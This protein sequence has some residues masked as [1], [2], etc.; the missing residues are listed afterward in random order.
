[1]LKVGVQVAEALAEIHAAHI[2]H[3]D[4]N[5]ANILY[6]PNTGQVKLIDFGLASRLSRE[7]PRLSSPEVMEGTLAYISPEQTGRMNCTVDF[8][9][10]LYSFGATLY[11]LLSG[12]PPFQIDEARKLVQCHLAQVP[13]TLSQV[14]PNVPA[15]LSELVMKL[16]SKAPERRYQSALGVKADLEEC[17][18]R[19]GPDGSIASFPL[20][21]L[22]FCSK[23]LVSQKLYGREQEKKRLLEGFEGIRQGKKEL[24]LVSGYS[25]VGKTALIRELHRP[26]LQRQGAFLSGKFDQLQRS[27]PYSAF[28]QAFGSFC[29]LLMGEPGERYAEW[30]STLQRALAPNGQ[31]LVEV[32]PELERILGPQPPVPELPPAERQHRFQ[33]VFEQLVGAVADPAHPLVLFIDDLQWADLASLQL[34]HQILRS[35]DIEALYL[36]GA[37]RDNEVD[38]THP[39]S[40]TLQAME[41]EG[42]P[43]QRLPLAPLGFDAVHQLV[44]DTLRSEPAATRDLAELFCLRSDGNPF[45]LNELLEA[46]CEEG[47]LE[48]D[49]KTYAWRWELSRLRVHPLTDR[50]ADL[51]A[52]KIQKLDPATREVLQVVACL[53]NHVAFADLA[54]ALDR[55]ASDL[56]TS[57]EHLQTAAMLVQLDSSLAETRQEY[58]FTHDKVQQSAYATLSKEQRERWHYGIGKKLLERSGEAAAFE[59]V[60]HWSLCLDLLREPAEQVSLSSMAL[61]AGK[62]AKES[63]AFQPALEYFKT[64]IALFDPGWW[65]EQA[66]L[67]LEL[68]LE[69][70][71]AHSLNGQYDQMERCLSTA[72]PHCRAPEERRRI[73]E[74]RILADISRNRNQEAVQGALEALAQLGIH[75]PVRATRPHIL[76]SLLKTRAMLLGRSPEVLLGLLDLPSPALRTAMRLMVDIGSAAYVSDINLYV[77]LVLRTFQISIRYGSTPYASVAYTGYGVLLCGVLNDPRIGYRYGQLALKNLDRFNE[78]R[79]RGY[80]QFVVATFITHWSRPLSETLKLYQDGYRHAIDNGDMIFASHLA[81]HYCLNACYCTAI[82]LDQVRCACAA[83]RDKLLQI[84]K[85]QAFYTLAITHQV[86][87]NLVNAPDDPGLLKGVAYDEESMLPIHSGTQDYTLVFCVYFTKL[88]LCFLSCDHLR[89]FEYAKKAREH[90][91]VVLGSYAFGVYHFYDSLVCLALDPGHAPLTRRTLLLR[92]QRNQRKLRRWARHAPENYLQKYLLV[93][94]ERLRLLGKDE[95]ATL[96]YDRAIKLAREHRF[97]SDEAHALEL[98]GL[99]HLSRDNAKLAKSYLQEARYAYLK[100]GVHTK[101]RDLDRRHAELGIGR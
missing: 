57:L 64:G 84:G 39:W 32:L 14:A 4:L 30:R 17:L 95:K 78:R 42:C 23:L 72:L 56:L 59:I 37:Y 33:H 27:R 101:V 87:L 10:D 82:E 6:N 51:M 94:A 41:Q 76:L 66:A 8:R 52:R 96:V 61:R 31:V 80:V 35:P 90:L 20:G 60:K 26:L 67:G 89:A 28:F 16:L 48:I 92:V 3:K 36:I 74:I 13:S 19:L 58:K 53:G 24:V 12:H 83:Y 49:P 18:Q 44:T 91:N 34:I 93:E 71:E 38:A 21:K 2:I 99:F 50:A 97:L 54:C 75:F 46:V 81:A 15:V 47:L 9:T 11:H 86:V 55:P 40:Q 1:M 73:L 62:R 22:D 45:L 98:A 68:H 79:L 5:P 25:G 29:R 43:I 77:L 88:F 70:A 63:A 7:T 100:W 85:S 69:G 65:G